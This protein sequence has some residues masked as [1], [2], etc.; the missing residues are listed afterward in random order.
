MNTKE[1]EVILR[2]CLEEKS[3]NPFDIINKMMDLQFCPMH[4]PEHHFMV[5]MALLTAYNNAG[6]DI[7]LEKSLREMIKR[8]KSVPGGACG[9]WGACGAGLSSGMFISI[10]SG[11]TPLGNENFSLSHQMTARSLS[12]IG[13]VGGPRCCKRDSC[14]SILSAADFVREHFGVCMEIGDI[15]CT[16]SVRNDQCIGSRCPFFGG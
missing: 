3:Q 14:L 9:Y 12:T 13:A 4:G 6:G 11:S 1:T 5:G 16:R 15:V 2:L 7:D 8:G 10:I